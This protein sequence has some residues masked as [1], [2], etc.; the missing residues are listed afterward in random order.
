MTNQK[1]L[2]FFQ[3][4]PDAET[5][6]VLD[7]L[8]L[9]N[10]FSN[11]GKMQYFEDF[12]NPNLPRVELAKAQGSPISI[13]NATLTQLYYDITILPNTDMWTS[14]EKVY[15]PSTGVYACSAVLAYASVSATVGLQQ[16]RILLYN[17]DGTFNTYIAFESRK[18]PFSGASLSTSGLIHA[19]AGQY[20]I[21]LGFQ[22]HGASTTFYGQLKV[23]K[24]PVPLENPPL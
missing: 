11:F 4:V 15:I 22:S 19:Y 10:N 23:A 16:L 24:L 14:G 18:L 12:G 8:T 7:I 3:Q 2:A 5:G 17:E 1:W 21:V 20:I 13:A 9:N 6:D